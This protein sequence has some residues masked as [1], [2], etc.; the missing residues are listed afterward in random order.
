M[1]RQDGISG[2]LEGW[3]WRYYTEKVRKARFD[4]DEEALRAYFEIDE[5][6]DG[7][8]S[9][10]NSLWGITFTE[11]PD[12]PR[13]HPD[14]QAFEVREADGRHIGV[15][16]WTSSPAPASAAEPG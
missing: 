6:R 2:R 8:F 10:A 12:L 16:Y 15:M 11:L 7:A 14:Q 4:I 1:M 9:I 5:V 13:W 3:D